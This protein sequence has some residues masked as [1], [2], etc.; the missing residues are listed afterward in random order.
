MVITTPPSSGS[1][2][3]NK[4]FVLDSDSDEGLAD[5]S[6]FIDLTTD[7]TGSVWQ[8]TSNNQADMFPKAMKNVCSEDGILTRSSKVFSNVNFNSFT[9]SDFYVNQEEKEATQP[10][11]GKKGVKQ[12]SGRGKGRGRGRG[13]K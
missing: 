9:G 11:N 6:E 7:E 13:R 3:T 10:S 1:R 2:K 4:R 12:V 8:G 5:K